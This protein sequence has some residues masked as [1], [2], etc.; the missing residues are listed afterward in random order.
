MDKANCFG[1][2]Q[3]P[4]S[5]DERTPPGRKYGKLAY[6]QRIK[7]RVF[8]EKATPSARRQFLDC[9]STVIGGREEKNKNTPGLPL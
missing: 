7:T 5:P 8:S 1:M 3:S 6:N 4:D 2:N 9:K